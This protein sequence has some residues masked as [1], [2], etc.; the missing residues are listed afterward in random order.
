MRQ[1]REQ[2]VHNMLVTWAGHLIARLDS[3]EGLGYSIGILQDYSGLP[4][5]SLIPKGVKFTSPEDI[6]VEN[7]LMQAPENIQENTIIKYVDRKP[8][9]ARLHTELLV[10]ARKYL[11]T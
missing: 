10:N 6:A 4:P 1:S 3:S 5:H 9:T 8:L 7:W 11:F 2:Q